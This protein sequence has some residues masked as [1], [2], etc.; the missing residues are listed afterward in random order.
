M[1]RVLDS[2]GSFFHRFSVYFGVLSTMDRYFLIIGREGGWGMYSIS[3]AVFRRYGVL[4]WVFSKSITT[5]DMGILTI[6]LSLSESS[7]SDAFC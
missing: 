4:V 1:F 6:I 2:G 5:M 7:I 3:G